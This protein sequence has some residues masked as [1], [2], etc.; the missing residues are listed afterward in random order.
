MGPMEQV[1]F[2]QSW[3]FRTK[4]DLGSLRPTPAPPGSSGHSWAMWEW[5]TRNGSVMMYLTETLGW[6]RAQAT[7]LYISAN[8]GPWIQFHLPMGETHQ[9]LEKLRISGDDPL[10]LKATFETTKERK[11]V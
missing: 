11:V 3:G 8:S 1:G 5:V 7:Y 9:S 2:P 6:V 10:R 4:I